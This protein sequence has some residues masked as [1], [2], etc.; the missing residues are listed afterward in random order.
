MCPSSRTRL[1][2]VVLLGALLASARPAQAVVTQPNGQ[3]V[4]LS[5]RLQALLNGSAA[6]NNINENVDE[7]RD[8]QTQPEKFSP[9]CDFSGR[10]VAKG[11]G[12]ESRVVA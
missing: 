9:L 7:Q 10:Y 2:G 8:A 3:V 12:D 11:G 6:N 1:L 5:G 4:P